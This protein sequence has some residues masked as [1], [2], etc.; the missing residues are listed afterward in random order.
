ML[1]PA[2]GEELVN[3][4]TVIQ[5]TGIGLFRQDLR[6]H[7]PP[8]LVSFYN[9]RVLCERRC[10][11]RRLTT[12][13]ETCSAGFNS[14]LNRFEFRALPEATELV[15]SISLDSEGRPYLVEVYH[16]E[17]EQQKT[18][19]WHTHSLT[20]IEYDFEPQRYVSGRGFTT[21][22]LCN[23]SALKRGKW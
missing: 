19:G 1:R 11:L 4:Y 6:Q 10:L 23:M 18:A 17:T 16:E 7:T 14:E 9:N 3:I 21:R 22:C 8:G 15:S 12:W 20:L 2:T 13:F 5:E